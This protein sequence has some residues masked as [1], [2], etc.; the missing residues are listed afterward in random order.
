MRCSVAGTSCTALLGD[1]SG[2]GVCPRLGFIPG[3]APS[4]ART[5]RA[6]SPARIVRNPSRSWTRPPPLRPPRAPPP[7]ATLAPPLPVQPRARPAH[8]QA[9]AAHLAGA[10]GLEPGWRRRL[11]GDVAQSVEQVQHRGLTPGADVERSGE[12]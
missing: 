5:C 11:I 10:L 6:Q 4:L 7:A 12:L 8:V 3:P 1:Q 2:R 9:A